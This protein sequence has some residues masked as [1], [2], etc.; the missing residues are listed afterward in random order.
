MMEAA[1]QF[2]GVSQR[3]GAAPVVE[4]NA[5]AAGEASG[6]GKAKLASSGPST[7]KTS[8]DDSSLASSHTVSEALSSGEPAQH[9]HADRPLGQA[10]P[11][12]AQGAQSDYQT[13]PLESPLETDSLSSGRSTPPAHP[14]RPIPASARGSAREPKLPSPAVRAQCSRDLGAEKSS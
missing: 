3:K 11:H 8:R 2:A 1:S 5:D 10:M 6:Q 9:S 14:M 12:S 13:S 4:A 7:P